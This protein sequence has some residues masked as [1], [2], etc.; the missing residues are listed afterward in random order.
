MMFPFVMFFT[1]SFTN[2]ITFTLPLMICI[3]LKEIHWDNVGNTWTIGKRII[4]TRTLENTRPYRLQKQ[5]K[6]IDNVRKITNWLNKLKVE[7]I[8]RKFISIIKIFYSYFL[9]TAKC[10]NNW[11]KASKYGRYDGLQASEQVFSLSKYF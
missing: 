3:F 2:P 11:N 9:N 10:N 4:R 6:W 5:N 8:K 7:M 1:Y